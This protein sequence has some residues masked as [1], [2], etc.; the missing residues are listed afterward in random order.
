ME[1]SGHVTKVRG[2]KCL[3]ADVPCLCVGSNVTSN[4]HEFSDKRVFFYPDE[5]FIG[6]E[7]DK[8][9]IFFV[10]VIPVNANIPESVP[11]PI[12]MLELSDHHK[13]EII[14]YGL[15]NGFEIKESDFIKLQVATSP[16]FHDPE[17]VYEDEEI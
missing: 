9:K 7:D 8:N 6:E 3:F 10:P 16:H 12:F 11:L 2:D 17:L 13:M 15:K 14:T 5:V 4:G 1:N